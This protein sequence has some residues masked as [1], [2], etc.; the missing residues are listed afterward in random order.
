MR[1]WTTVDLRAR[2]ELET[3]RQAS[4]RSESRSAHQRDQQLCTSARCPA[5]GPGERPG[6]AD[7]CR[8]KSPP[9]QE[10]AGAR[11]RRSQSLPEQEPAGARAC[12]SKSPPEGTERRGW[13]LDEVLHQ[14]LFEAVGI[15]GCRGVHSSGPKAAKPKTWQWR[16]GED[17]KML[18]VVRLDGYPCSAGPDQH[19]DGLV[20]GAARR[21][22]RLLDDLRRE[23]PPRR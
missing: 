17:H 5:W 11:A 14:R 22:G 3:G 6:V 7:R 9:E 12:R 16:L 15:S 21:G 1:L 10:P 19:W 8:S 2:P 13:V 18:C 20:T 23:R 4:G